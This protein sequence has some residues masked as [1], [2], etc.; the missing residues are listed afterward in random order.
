MNIVLIGYRCSGKTTV[1]KILA[2][3]L[4]RDFLDTDLLIKNHAGCGIEIIISRDGWGRFRDME[5]SV[6]KEVSDRDNLVI[7]AGGGVVT[8]KD[9]VENLKRNGFVVWLKGDIEVLKQRMNE[10]RISGNLRPSLTGVD[11]TDEIKRVLDKRNPFYRRVGNLEVDTSL[12]SA[13]DVA[14]SILLNL[15]G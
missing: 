11:P 1:G 14:D 5:K 15:P 9:N 12:L 7:A 3:E 8:D 4:K 13:R 10:D 6:I 2:T